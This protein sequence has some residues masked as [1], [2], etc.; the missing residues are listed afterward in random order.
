MEEEVESH[1]GAVEGRFG[2]LE[3]LEE[4]GWEVVG[5]EG[6]GEEGGERDEGCG[7]GEG[8]AGG[9]FG[10]GEAEDDGVA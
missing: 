4:E 5:C 10:G 1:D 7:V 3:G 8:V 9:V 2:Q 6:A